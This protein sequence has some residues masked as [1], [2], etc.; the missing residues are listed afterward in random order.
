M[1]RSKYITAWSWVGL[2]QTFEFEVVHRFPWDCAIE[3]RSAS[4]YWLNGGLRTPYSF[5]RV[6]SSRRKDP[7]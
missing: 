4:S 6:A 3:R 7:L 1:V 5:C 2:F